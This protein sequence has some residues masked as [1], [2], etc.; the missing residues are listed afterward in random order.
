VLTV[1]GSGAVLPATVQPLLG[2]LANVGLALFMFLV[3]Y[4][5]D[6]SFLQGRRPAALSLA[7]G[8]VLLPLV[9]G[10]AV[11]LPLTGRY[12][13]QGRVPFVLF[14]GV[15]MSVTAFPVLARIL[16]DRGL[17]RQPL[18]GVTLAAAAIG[19]LVAW[20]CLAGVVA[21]AGAAGQWKIA[22]LPVYLL[23]L[24]VVVR[25]LVAAGLRAA[26]RRGSPP[27]ELVPLLV[28][29]LMLSCA[30]TEW[31]GIH[32]VFGAFAFGAIIPKSLSAQ[33]RSHIVERTEQARSIL[34]P[35]YF[36][37]AGTRVSRSG[38]GLTA[39]G[40][41]AAV[42]VVAI[43]TKMAGAYG[44]ARLAGVLRAEAATM[45]VLMN[46][47]GLTEIVIITVGLD[48]HLIDRQF[49]SVMVVMAVLTTAMTGPL[50][51]L[52]GPPAGADRHCKLPSPHDADPGAG[53]GTA[54]CSD[55]R[56]IQEE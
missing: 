41:L 53:A 13:P 9:G 15:A 21:L 18:G 34:L 6:A 27:V 42:L 40:A 3:G 33:L 36:V 26:D 16:A 43:A 14:V 10:M 2:A 23:V 49:Y 51:R 22:L 5:L 30:A 39:L 31:L 44:G 56:E 50:L 17:N 28:V 47:R 4:E 46:T 54:T 25:P 12:A 24:L 1:A 11:A 7:A 19:D 45:A 35:L 55:G 38:F 29:G 37:E 32:F 48:L 20:L 8:S 52:V